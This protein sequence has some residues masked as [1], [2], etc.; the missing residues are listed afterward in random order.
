MATG[1]LT[2]HRRMAKKKGG[3]PTS[4]QPFERVE[5]QAPPDWVVQL[6]TAARAVGLSR[7][8][9]IRLACNKLMQADHKAKGGE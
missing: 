4:E 3:K 5:F 8:A 2:E 7:S 9:Y 6:D 1:I